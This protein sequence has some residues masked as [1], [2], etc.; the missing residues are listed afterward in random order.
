MYIYSLTFPVWYKYHTAALQKIRSTLQKMSKKFWLCYTCFFESA[1]FFCTQFFCKESAEEFRFL[2]SGI[3]KRLSV[4]VFTSRLLN[5]DA[6]VQ[7]NYDSVFFWLQYVNVRLVNSDLRGSSTHTYLQ[8]KRAK[9][10]KI[11]DIRKNICYKFTN[12]FIWD[13]FLLIL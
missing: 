8:I 11:Y 4:S 7:S 5:N 3:V 2:L 12:L 13:V 10:R 6:K 1:T 9:I